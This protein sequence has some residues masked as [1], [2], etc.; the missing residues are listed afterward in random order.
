MDDTLV[1]NAALFIEI[2]MLIDTLK[3]AYRVYENQ[4]VGVESLD[5]FHCQRVMWLSRSLVPTTSLVL[6]QQ[7]RDIN[8]MVH[9]G[10]SFGN[11]SRTRS[12]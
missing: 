2:S 5:K 9:L 11:T 8:W 3:P 10:L 1:T 7:T 6:A 12:I 4:K